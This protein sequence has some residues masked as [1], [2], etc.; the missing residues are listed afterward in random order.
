[1]RV[2][3]EPESRLVVGSVGL[4]GPPHD[5]DVEMG[6]GIDEPHRRLGY[7]LEAA[8]GLKAWVLAQ[9]DVR[10]LSATIEDQNLA[11]QRLATKLGLTRTHFLRRALPLWSASA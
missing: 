4:K 1:M 7:G 3:V 10:T 5:G 9:P 2:V 6:W 11:S 8:A